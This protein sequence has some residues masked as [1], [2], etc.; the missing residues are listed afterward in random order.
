MPRRLSDKLTYAN[1]LATLAMFVSLGGASYAAITLP[2]GS[3]G[4]KQLRARAVGIEALRFPL[5]TVGTTDDKI[6]DLTKNGCNGGGF[7]GIV[8]PDCTPGSPGGPTPGREVHILLRSSGRLLV[9]AVVSLKNEGSPQ[10]TS[11]ITLGLTV[12]R[13]RVAENQIATTGGQ[14]VQVPIQTLVNVLAGSHTAGV[15][16]RAEYDS[17]TP[18]DVL[19]SATSV[20]ASALPGVEANQ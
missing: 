3:V 12:D 13:H 6:E 10:T 15:T 14:I 4:A 17:S 7:T 11:R 20:I 16:V 9:S 5:G 18:G 19:V 8:A 2:A 1:V